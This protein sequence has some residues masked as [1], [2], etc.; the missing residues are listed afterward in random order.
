[1]ALIATTRSRGCGTK[2][3]AH[4]LDQ[5]P[6]RCGKEIEPEADVAPLYSSHGWL[7]GGSS[8]RPKDG[9]LEGCDDSLRWAMKRL[10]I[11]S[12]ED[13]EDMF[14]KTAATLF[15]FLG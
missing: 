13:R 11:K 4:S 10:P 14:G 2:V 7:L 6:L 9:R 8:F 1:M 3:A 5:L 15:K 12:D